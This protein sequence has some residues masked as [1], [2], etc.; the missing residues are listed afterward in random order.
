MWTSA[1]M[2][3][4]NNAVNPPE[5][6]PAIVVVIQLAILLLL[7]VS[8]WKVFVKAGKPGWA[9]IV[10]FYNAFV[11]ID[12]AGKPAWWVILLFIPV[13]GLIALIL[14]FIEVAKRFGKSSLFGIGLALLPFI[15]YPILAFGDAK[16][17]GNT[18]EYD[19]E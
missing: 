19:D 6:P 8:M 12:I 4:Q 9:S 1:L 14:V 13:V 16:Y 7:I 15:F 5:A 11:L 2:L 3:A 18:N 17:Q 10:P